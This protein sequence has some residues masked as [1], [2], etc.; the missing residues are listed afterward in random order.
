V[1]INSTPNAIYIKTEA[2]DTRVTV[3]MFGDNGGITVEGAI[4]AP[5]DFTEPEEYLSPNEDLHPGDRE[6]TDEGAQGFT[7]TD[8]R[9][10]TYPDGTKEV[11]VWTWTY[12]PHSIVYEVHPCE[13][14]PGHIQYDASIKCPVQVPSVLNLT[15]A[16]ATTALNNVGLVLAVGAPIVDGGAA[17]VREQNR[18]PGSWVDPGTTVTVRI[19]Q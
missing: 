5:Y 3:K 13:L 4:S 10:I 11:K 17:T 12:A 1:F 16:A 7:A 9:T 14:P 6:L 2:T 18:S 8:T 15:Q 19:G